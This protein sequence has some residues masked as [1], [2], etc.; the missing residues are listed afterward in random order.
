MGIRGCPL[1]PSSTKTREPGDLFTRRATER[2]GLNGPRCDLGSQTGTAVFPV[3]LAH[4]P[5]GSKRSPSGTDTDM[6]STRIT[7]SVRKRGDCNLPVAAPT[8]TCREIVEFPAPSL[9]PRGQFHPKFKSKPLAAH[10]CSRASSKPANPPRFKTNVTERKS[11]FQ[12]T[13]AS[14]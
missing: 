2:Y 5:T 3:S 4:T 10:R 9:V 6:N 8:E 12:A 11:K 7:A 13:E 1:R 14:K